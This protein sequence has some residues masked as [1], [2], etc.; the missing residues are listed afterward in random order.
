MNVLAIFPLNWVDAFRFFFKLS[1]A[2]GDW[3][4]LFLPV[5]LTNH[6]ARLRT[7]SVDAQSAICV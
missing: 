5:W 4:K 1:G 7:M 6:R 2:N 3:G